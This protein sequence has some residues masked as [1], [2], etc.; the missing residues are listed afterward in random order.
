MLLH[1]TSITQHEILVNTRD[2]AIGDYLDKV[3]RAFQIPWENSMPG[4]ALE[5]WSQI[6]D[7]SPTA[8]SDDMKRWELPKPLSTIQKNVLAFS[9]TGVR[10]SLE[11]MVESRSLDDSER[12][13]LARAAQIVSFQHV[14]DKCILSIKSAYSSAKEGNLV[15]SGGVACN[16]AFRKM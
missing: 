6:N 5:K 2:T 12:R 16:L 14:I 10:T 1:S 9:F 13:S 4:A 3:A 11:R 15:V 8:L 7:I